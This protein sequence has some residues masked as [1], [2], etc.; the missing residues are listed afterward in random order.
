MLATLR[1]KREMNDRAFKLFLKMLPIGQNPFEFEVKYRSWVGM[2]DLPVPRYK[3]LKKR[4]GFDDGDFNLHMSNSSYPKVLC[5]TINDSTCLRCFIR[6]ST[7]LDSKRPCHFFLLSFVLVELWLLVVN[8]FS[9]SSTQAWRI[10]ITYFLG[11]HFVFLREIPLFS[12]Y[13]VRVS[14]GTWDRKWVS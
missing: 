4:L 13:E 3:K 1:S 14:V 12:H 8:Y 6:F 10:D 5:S 11:T 9:L 2:F 7:W